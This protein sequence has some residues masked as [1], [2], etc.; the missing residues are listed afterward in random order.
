MIIVAVFLTFSCKLTLCIKHN[1]AQNVSNLQISSFFS[2][3]VVHDM[4]LINIV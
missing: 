4:I 1:E 3:T 2:S